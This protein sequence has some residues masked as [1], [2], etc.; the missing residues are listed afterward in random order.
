MHAMYTRNI[1]NAHKRTNMW[2]KVRE[3]HI[4]VVNSI[5]SMDQSE[6][7]NSMYWLLSC[8]LVKFGALRFFLFFLSFASPLKLYVRFHQVLTWIF[9]LYAC[10]HHR[11]LNI[12]EQPKQSNA[13]HTWV[14]LCT[15]DHL[16]TVL[17]LKFNTA[18]FLLLLLIRIHW[19]STVLRVFYTL[20][21]TQT[22]TYKLDFDCTGQ[23]ARIGKNQQ[24]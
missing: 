16:R 14:Y 22:H 10:Q 1:Q 3:R 21:T 15:R 12:A 19:K 8:L 17:N 7:I 11:K 6:T 2:T 20:Y 9:R 13:H 5:W 23:F 18:L 24:F 4:R